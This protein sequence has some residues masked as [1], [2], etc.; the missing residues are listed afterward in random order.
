MAMSKGTGN[1]HDL[2]EFLVD[3]PEGYGS[4][5]F[6]GRGALSYSESVRRLLMSARRVVRIAV[7]FVDDCGIDFLID[8]LS[9][10][11]NR[12]SVEMVVRSIPE[13]R[14][15]DV[16]KAGIRLYVLNEDRSRWGFHAKYFIFDDETAI[17]GSENLVDRNLRRSLEIGVMVGSKIS[18]Q[19]LVVHKNLI[20]VSIKVV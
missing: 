10:N 6:V 17:I 12:P 8:G 3:F 13:W 18:N 14:T 15:D 16:K 2:V 11:T 7:P 1:E 19:L 20:A 4:V 5:S 9:A